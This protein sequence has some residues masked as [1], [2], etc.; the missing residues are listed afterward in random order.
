MKS[1]DHLLEL[2]RRN[3]ET[4]LGDVAADYTEEELAEALYDEVYVLAF[5]AL[6]D[7]GVFHEAARELARQIAEPY[8]KEG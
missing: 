8:K 5:D 7:N 2:A 4:H 3:V 6:V 1:K